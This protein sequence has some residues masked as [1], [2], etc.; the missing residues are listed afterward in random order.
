MGGWW[1]FHDCVCGSVKEDVELGAEAASKCVSLVIAAER[2]GQIRS[3][4][5]I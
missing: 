1:A 3:D 4:K 2:G 5:H